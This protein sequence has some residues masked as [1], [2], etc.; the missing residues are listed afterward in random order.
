MVIYSFQE[1][2][3]L[4]L[5]PFFECLNWRLMFERALRNTVVV[6][7]GVVAQG[8]FKLCGVLKAGLIDDLADASVETFDHAVGLRMTWRNEAMLDRGAFAL[9]IEY[10]FAGWYPVAVFIL[11][12]AGE[13]CKLTAVIGEQ[14]DDFDRTG[15]LDFGQEIDTAAV[16]LIIVDVHVYPADGTVNRDEQIAPC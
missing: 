13:A 8:R 2:L 11:F 10:M 5:L 14:F 6:D 4:I 9:N 16:G 3:R 1:H 12:P 15:R 7:F